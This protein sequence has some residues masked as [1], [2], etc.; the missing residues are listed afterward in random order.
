MGTVYLI[1][2]E[3]SIGSG[4]RGQARHYLGYTSKPLQ[5]RLD[6]HRKGDGARLMQ[7]ISEKGIGWSVVRKWT[8]NRGLE[9]QLKARHNAPKLCPIC[10]LAETNFGGTHE[11][12]QNDRDRYRTEEIVFGAGAS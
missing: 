10:K 5:E 2:F 1:H 8:G 3:R 12:N 11:R 4:R 9:K 7:V 6:R